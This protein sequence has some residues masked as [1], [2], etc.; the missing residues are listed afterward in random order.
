MIK[1]YICR[2]GQTEGNLNSISQGW[3]DSPLT[4]V[5][6]EHAKKLSF[7]LSKFGIKKIISS[8]IGRAVETAKIINSQLMKNILLSPEIREITYGE[9]D[10]KPDDVLIREN[11]GYL[12]LS[13]QFPRGESPKMFI[14][15]ISKFFS[16]FEEKPLEAKIFSGSFYDCRGGWIRQA[17]YVPN[18]LYSGTNVNEKSLILRIENKWRLG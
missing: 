13:Y 5:G 6:I 1:G 8:D 3:K 9:Y 12:S 18:R 17:E 15:R 11:V 14:E 16:S 4:N 2:H 10:G 7:K